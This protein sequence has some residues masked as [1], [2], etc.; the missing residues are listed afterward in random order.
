MSET[1][2]ETAWEPA[3]S[4]S[5]AFGKPQAKQI[6]WPSLTQLRKLNNAMVIKLTSIELGYTSN[7]Y[8]IR[9]N[10][11][12][13]VKSE[14]LCTNQTSK[15]TQLSKLHTFPIDPTSRIADVYIC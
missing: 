13:G 5:E 11:S 12:G 6:E 1:A 10:F 3:L 9:L 2:I 4:K 7:L 8:E 14:G 15:S